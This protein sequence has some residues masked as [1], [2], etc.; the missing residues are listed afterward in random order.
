MAVTRRQWLLGGSLVLTLIA[1]VLAPKPDDASVVQP[2]TGHASSTGASAPAS[3]AA[4][5]VAGDA[6]LRVLA[7]RPRH[8]AKASTLFVIP[9]PPRPVLLSPAALGPAVPVEAPLPAY[10]LIG[11]YDT[12]SSQTLLLASGKDTVE[13]QVGDTV[14]NGWRI[15]NIS[16]DGIVFVSP[17]GHEQL[18][19]TGDGQ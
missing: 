6:D 17:L 7:L 13:A 1:T 16:D 4:T 15:K 8:V 9:P 14:G 12:G 18:L 2:E 11:R 5:P 10:S 3:M 19:P